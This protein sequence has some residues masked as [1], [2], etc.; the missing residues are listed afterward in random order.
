MP[1]SDALAT[2]SLLII[3]DDDSVRDVLRRAFEQRGWR[4]T[5]AADASSAMEGIAAG[6]IDVCLVDWQLPGMD[7]LALL[8][9][10]RAHDADVSLVMM[11]GEA[12]VSTAV[13][14]MHAGAETM[15][16]KP[17][18]L[19]HVAMTLDRAAEKAQLRRQNRVLAERQVQQSS[20]E[21]LGSAPA[22]REL[23]KQLTLLAD[24]SAPVLIAGETGSGKGWAA[25][26]VH[27]A[28]PRANGPFV[29]VNCAGLSA[30][31]LDSELFG[32]ERGAYTDAKTRKL[33]L[34]EVAH[35]GTLMLDEIGDL[36]PELQPKL[37]TVLETQR[38]RRLGGTQE[39][40]VDVRVIAATHVDLAAAVR[41]GRFREDLYYR[42]AVLPVRIPSLRERGA[43][44]IAALAHQLLS[45]LRRSFGRGPE[46]I[47]EA[48]L[49]ALVRYRWPGNV[50]E[51]RNVLERAIVLAGPA[52]ELPVDSLPQ[53]ISGA[54]PRRVSEPAPQVEDLTLKTAQ[55]RHI[56]RVLSLT[57]GNRHQAAR[58][59]DVSRQ[60]LYNYVP[61][62]RSKDEPA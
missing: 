54:L 51:L 18:E 45:D 25:K 5:T 10:L 32:H 24:G 48:A 33:G 43:A 28:S 42:L 20:F 23:A 60:T 53:E 37:L 59:L 7:G 38:F 39:L 17:L 56:E 9:E 21:S 12:D 62:P 61:S 34:F 3:D 58:L 49:E 41:A 30:T 2:R 50:R 46:R 16:V 40:Q 29:S 36:A 19:E 22:M 27:A 31:F 6:P 15:L 26:L 4:V 47:S 52:S 57:S 11:S 44:G 35:G 8:P 14:A 1:L 13:A 55:R